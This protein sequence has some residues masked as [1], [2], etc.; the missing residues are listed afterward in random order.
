MMKTLKIFFKKLGK[1]YINSM[2]DF[3]QVDSKQLY[4]DRTK[5]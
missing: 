4:N 5:Y 1:A 3:Y 2:I